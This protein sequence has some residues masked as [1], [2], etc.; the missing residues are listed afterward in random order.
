[1]QPVWVSGIYLK[2]CVWTKERPI[3]HFLWGEEDLS[4]PVRS[5]N[6]SPSQSLPLIFMMSHLAG[7]MDIMIAMIDRDLE[8]AD[9]MIAMIE[10][11]KIQN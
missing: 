11:S 9:I 5:K 8:N 1:M 3:I 7:N 4:W 10:T 2:S 6:P